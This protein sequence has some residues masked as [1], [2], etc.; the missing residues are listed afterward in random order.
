MPSIEIQAWSSLGGSQP[1][2]HVPTRT[3]Y[4]PGL[5]VTRNASI[6]D[7][8]IA[9]ASGV[10]RQV[11][12]SGENQTAGVVSSSLPTGSPLQPARRYPFGS[13]YTCPTCAPTR[14]PL[15]IATGV[16]LAPSAKWKAALGGPIYW[17]T[18]SKKADYC[19]ECHESYDR[20]LGGVPEGSRAWQ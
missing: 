18:P 7:T 10:S 17:R 4:R 2:A 15:R 12:P 3:T 11:R 14:S 5:L 19:V 20:N 8:A 1:Q 6:V 16:H 13:M 9:P